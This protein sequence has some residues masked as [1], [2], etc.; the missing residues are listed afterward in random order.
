MRLEFPNIVR[1]VIIG[2]TIAGSETTCICL[3][4]GLVFLQHGVNISSSAVALTI[5]SN[6]IAL[7][8]S[9]Y[10]THHQRSMFCITSFIATS[11]WIRERCAMWYF[12]NFV[13]CIN[14]KQ[15]RLAQTNAT[16]TMLSTL[17]TGSTANSI[18]CT[19]EPLF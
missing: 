7:L 11:T 4:K 14:W 15:H 10:Y 2:L 8:A 1:S 9:S 16:N 17:C 19:C 3:S 18:L 5:P 13:H 12:C 6:S